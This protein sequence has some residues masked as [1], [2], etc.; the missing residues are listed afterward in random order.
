[1]EPTSLSLKSIKMR[2]IHLTENAEPMRNGTSASLEISF[3]WSR[4]ATNLDSTLFGK[5]E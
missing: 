1:M 4:T 3:N 5:Q 2:E